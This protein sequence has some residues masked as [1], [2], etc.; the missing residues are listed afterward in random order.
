MGVFG[1][2]HF[3]YIGNFYEGRKMDEKYLD[4]MVDKHCK[5]ITK[6]PGEAKSIVIFGII[7]GIDYD[8]NIM[9]VSSENGVGCLNIKTVEAIKPIRKKFREYAN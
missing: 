5:I 6:L 3:L 2:Y 1:I 8:A 9:I 4:N 7:I